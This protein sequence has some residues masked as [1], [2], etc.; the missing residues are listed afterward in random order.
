MVTLE[1][2]KPGDIEA[3]SF[4]LIG[5][6]LSRM[7]IM[8]DPRHEHIIKRCI[9]TS[10]DMDFA[11]NMKF[12][13]DAVPKIKEAIKNGCYIIT[14]TK[15][16]QSGIDKARLDVF[17]SS[18]LCF[19]GSQDVVQESKMEGVTKA[20]ISMRKAKV[21][22]KPVVFAIGNSPT[23]IQSILEMNALGEFSPVAV[24]GT[25]A[26]FVNVEGSKE[27]LIESGIPYIVSR[28]R[29]GG[30]DIA[31]A[32]VNAIQYSITR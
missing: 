12:S 4:Q 32:I 26:G 21:L 7:G 31:S 25:P 8:L 28:G 29:K 16:V 2:L 9:H 13:D 19:V 10:A 6:E 24:I 14:D 11:T 17:G 15:I 22:D 5:E 30:N 23:A 27:N 3:K 20:Y 1:K 18:V